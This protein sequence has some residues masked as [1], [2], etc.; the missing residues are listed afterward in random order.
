VIRIG[1]FGT[2]DVRDVQG[3]EL[4]GIL[5][6]PKRLALLA[7]LAAASPTGSHRRDTLLGL[8]WPELDQSHA[9]NALSQAVHFLRRALGEEVLIARTGDELALDSTRV[10]VDV[11]AFNAALSDD[12]PGEAL[13]LYRGDL[14]PSFFLSGCPGFE[15]WLES[16]RDRLRNRAAEAARRLAEGHERAA[17]LTLAAG[18][19]HRAIELGGGDERHLRRMVEL[20][21]RVGDRA[22]AI[23]AYERWTATLAD[24]S[25]EPEAETLQLIRQVRAALTQCSPM[26]SIPALAVTGDG[27]R[28]VSVNDAIGRL[29]GALAGAYRLEQE[30]GAGAMAVVVRARDL[31]HQRLVAIKILR[32]ELTAAMGA[33]RFLREIEIAAGLVHPHILPLHDSGEAAGVLYYVMPYVEGE[34]LRQRLARERRLP[35]ADA[36]RITRE[37]AAALGYAHARGFVHRDIKPENILLAGYPLGKSGVPQGWN[38]VIADF[39]IARAIGTAGG[40]RVVTTGLSGTPAYMSPEQALGSGPV[41][42]RTDVYALGC[43]LYEMLAGQPPYAGSS[44]EAVVARRLQEPPRR[45]TDLRE[46]ASPAM[47]AAVNTALARNPAERFAT[48]AQLA[49]AL[50]GAA[51]VAPPPYRRWSVAAAIALVMAGATWVATRPSPPAPWP[52]RV[53]T[54]AVLPVRTSGDSSESYLADGISAGLTGGLVR[55]DGLAVRPRAEVLAEAG[56]GGT[57]VEVGRRMGADWVVDGALR[58]A[59]SRSRLVVE[60]IHVGRG[61][62]LWSRDYESPAADLLALR[63]SATTEVA[64]V[65]GV[66]LS[67]TVHAALARRETADL[68]ARDYYLRGSAAL[69]AP[70][71]EAAV[72]AADLFSQAVA[73]DSTYADAWAGLAAAYQQLSQVGGA[74]PMETLVLWRRA[75]DRAIA[76]D[77]LNGD[78]YAQRAQIHEVYEWDFPAADADF[79]RAVALRPGSAETFMSYAQFLNVGGLDDS[80]LAVMQRAVAL[81]PDVS[82]R[83]ANLVPRL[84]MVG[85]REEAAVEARRAL[86][87]DSTLWVAHLML[88]QLADDAGNLPQA[89]KE[90]ELAFQLTGD[91]PFVLGTLAR[92]WGL[93]G[94]AQQAKQVRSRL[95]SLQTSQHVERVFDAEALIGVGDPQGALDALEASAR[96]REPDLLWKLAYGH[97]SRLRAEPRY[98]ALLRRVGV[99]DHAQ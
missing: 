26:S 40:E 37:V 82:F 96:D 52:E 29:R 18:C 11:R 33:E 94:R 69:N 49:E 30:V 10:W 64:R 20:L 76:L 17:H 90:A 32:P 4:Q 23:R 77:S 79:R 1:L 63:Q 27:V 7:Y 99:G 28:P 21:A 85:R 25:L 98:Q 59:G 46:D 73:R 88:A 44:L 62:A 84:R 5:A 66:P 86:A 70:S 47:E 3:R 43:V 78:A 74:S 15:E 36:V 91:L 14:L 75:I 45:L 87:L 39:G 8:F 72:M 95:T 9:R 58:R 31:R 89:A 57:P 97:F 12:R 48:A 56:K 53:Q 2:I 51:A 6:Q 83:V 50:E 55:I 65:I 68:A 61:I 22:G 93:S 24:L 67:A 42:Q 71:T 16:E 38:A 19:A 54:V 13:E 92:Y 35:L 34:S 81:S 41:D 80:A 60:L